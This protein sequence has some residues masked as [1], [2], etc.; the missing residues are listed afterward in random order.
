[1]NKFDDI[2]IKELNKKEAY[3]QNRMDEEEN[4]G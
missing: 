4:E 2:P 3:K 1:M